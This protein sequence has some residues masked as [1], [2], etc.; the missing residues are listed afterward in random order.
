M[1]NKAAV[2][3]PDLPVITEPPKAAARRVARTRGR[4]TR[5]EGEV[6]RKSILDAALQVFI[7]RGLK[8]ASM[9][10]IAREAGVAK[11]TLYRHYETKEQL[12]VEVARRAQLSVRARLGTVANDDVPLETALR[13][14]ITKL[15]DGYTHPDYLAVMRM[16]I[17][18]AGRFPKLG[19]AMLEDSQH[20]SEPLVAYLQ[21]L[22]DK[23]LV[24][25]DS[26]YDAAVQISGMASGA[27]RYVL[28]TPSRH[29]ASRKRWVESL[30]S[31]FVKAWR[32]PKP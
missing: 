28:L 9:E 1:K 5:E 3:S 10:G 27:G 21:A 16:V 19:R 11:I 8:A 15:Y 30:V 24:D 7:A 2:S 12:F 29:P 6:L 32:M 17:A 14:I 31:L 23:G 13:A 26:P 4:P 25:I 20:I 22:K 18:E